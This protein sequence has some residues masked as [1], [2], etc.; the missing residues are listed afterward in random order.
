MGKGA[1]VRVGHA[2]VVG[3]S[4]PKA[5]WGCVGLIH[6]PVRAALARNSAEDMRR[7]PGDRHLACESC[8]HQVVPE[9][10]SWG[11]E[12]PPFTRTWRISRPCRSDLRQRAVA[13]CPLPSPH[14]NPAA[15]Q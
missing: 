15:T 12:A 1:S 3:R 2:P 14:S 8:V 6:R 9:S 11:P 13:S 4:T 7:S 10:S 5:A